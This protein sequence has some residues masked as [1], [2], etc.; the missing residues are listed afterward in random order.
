LTGEI[1]PYITQGAIS[2]VFLAILANF[3][4]IHQFFWRFRPMFSEFSAIFTNI[5]TTK[6]GILLIANVRIIFLQYFCSILR[7]NR[8]LFAKPFGQ[9]IL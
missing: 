5:S 3:L 7:K 2:L 9:T 6:S 4:A 8:A 1:L